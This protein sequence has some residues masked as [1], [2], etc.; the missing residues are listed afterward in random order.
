MTLGVVIP[1]TGRSI[2]W[3]RQAT[4]WLG[5]NQEELERKQLV[6]DGPVRLDEPD[7]C[8]EEYGE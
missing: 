2:P 5:D 8:L 1:S 3:L 6:T 4:E 7:R